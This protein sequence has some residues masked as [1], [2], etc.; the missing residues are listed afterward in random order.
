M[1]LGGKVIFAGDCPSQLDA[2]PS[3]HIEKLSA[4]GICIPFEEQAIVSAIRSVSGEYIS[5][6]NPDGT[7]ERAVFAQV[8][9]AFCGD[10][11]ALVLLNTDRDAPRKNLTVTIRVPSGCHLQKWDLETG[12]RTDADSILTRLEDSVSFPVSLEAAGTACFV[13]TPEQEALPALADY[14]TVS[15]TI[16]D[17][18]FT[19]TRDEKN[20]CVLDW[21]RWRWQGGEFSPEQEA[22]KADQAVRDTLNLEHRGGEMLQPWFAKLH[23]TKQY[24]ELELEYTFEIETL[25]TGEVWLAGERPE[26]NHYRINGVSLTS[27]DVNDFWVDECFKKMRIPDGVLKTG[28]NTVTVNVTFMRTTNIEA[29]YLIGDFGV[30][31]SGRTRTLT[32]LPEVIGCSNFEAYNLPFYTGAMTYHLPAESVKGMQIAADERIV[33]TPVQ[34]TG[35][36]AKVT[37]AGKTTVLGWEPYE[38][39]VTE[40]VLAGADIDVTIV[41]TRRNVFGPLHESVKIASSYGPG[42]FVTTGDR[43][44]DDYSLIDSGLRGIA[45]KVQKKR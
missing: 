3:D 22:L 28:T 8:R 35:G 45:L 41:G 42:N 34:F 9:S 29:L 43:W 16:L 27:E 7:A 15:E 13:L 19:Y 21:L 12:A 14:E 17:G 36:C 40:A 39:D 44:T 10:S 26:W 33:L 31:V 6:T 24:G 23:D 1:S 5:V 2:V 37:A 38:A 4:G 32:T 11:H 30:S 25:P 20:V 18:D